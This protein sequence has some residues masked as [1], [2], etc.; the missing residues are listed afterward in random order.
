MSTERLVEEISECY[1][2]KV[3]NILDTSVE[4]AKAINL[5]KEKLRNLSET[6]VEKVT[7]TPLNLK[8][9]TLKGLEDAVREK[10]KGITDIIPL[11]V[12][13]V[14]SKKYGE[15][16]D[17][18][19][20]DDYSEDS[21]FNIMNIEWNDEIISDEDMKKHKIWDRDGAYFLTK[22]KKCKCKEESEEDDSADG[23]S[24]DD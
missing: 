5:L 7:K 4:V 3:E 22:P 11:K 10:Y 16:I 18:L 24:E 9:R 23:K 8:E 19:F 1:G 17:F 20:Q 12:E 2:D 21:L 15:G 6:L 14:Q 13:Y